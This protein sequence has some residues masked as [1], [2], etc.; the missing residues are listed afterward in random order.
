MATIKGN[1][2][3]LAVVTWLVWLI[4]PPVAI[5]K[6]QLFNILTIKVEQTQDRVYVRT[7][8]NGHPA[9]L[10]LNTGAAASIVSAA[11]AERLG[12]GAHGNQ[13]DTGPIGYGMNGLFRVSRATIFIGP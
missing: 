7:E 13:I 3:A 5:A 12:L 1:S 8:I 9:R 6:C 2:L 10:I 4:G 11:A